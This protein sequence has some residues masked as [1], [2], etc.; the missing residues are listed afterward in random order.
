MK[1]SVVILNWNGKTLMEEYLPNVI[2]NTLFETEKKVEIII[3][4]NGSKDG[5]VEFIKANYSD[6]IKCIELNFNHG[7]AEGYN[8]ALAEIDSKYAVLLNSD[9]KVTQ[10]WLDVLID[11]MEA[12]PEVAACQPKIRS[13]RQEEYF[14]HAGAAGGFIDYLGY[15]F[16]RGRVLSF[17]EKDN[18]QYDAPIDLFW[19]TGACL[20]VRMDE[21]RNVGGFDARFF[22]HMEEID[23]CWRFRSR[24]KRIVCLPQSCVYHLGGATLN[25]ENPRKT[26]LNYRN[27]LLM[28]YKN[29]TGKT[30]NKI[31]VIRLFLDYLSLFVFLL[32]GK[33]GDAKAVFRARYHFWKLKPQFKLQRVENLK[34]TNTSSIPEVYKGSMVFDYYFRGKRYFS[35]FFPEIKAEK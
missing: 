30:Y 19:A 24:G 26:F 5:S 13:L 20:C 2:S 18:G 6:K 35:D 4:D 31:F 22:A 16:C 14:E 34:K 15:P 21:F 28:L 11:Y 3:A 23:L 29:T 7:F 17:V 10:G 33:F 8:L 1:T 12:H 32:L 25:K 9:V 27:N